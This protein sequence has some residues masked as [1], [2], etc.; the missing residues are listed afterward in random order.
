M[1]NRMH[2]KTVECSVV[3]PTFALARDGRID[4]FAGVHRAFEVV[5][6]VRADAAAITNFVSVTPVGHVL[7]KKARHELT[8]S[9]RDRL[10]V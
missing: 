6:A 9:G 5:R 7:C 10:G 2:L 4:A 3:P 1:A 8:V